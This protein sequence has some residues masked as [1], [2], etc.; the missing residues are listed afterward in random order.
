MKSKWKCY[1][2][3]YNEFYEYETHINLWC[4][5]DNRLMDLN[6]YIMKRPSCFDLRVDYHVYRC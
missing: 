1:I 3:G 4:L 5:E 2:L 6:D